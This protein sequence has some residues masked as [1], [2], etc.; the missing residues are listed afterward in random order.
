[1]VFSGLSRARGRWIPASRASPSSPQRNSPPERVT[2]AAPASGPAASP[3]P[4]SAASFPAPFAA[5]TKWAGIQSHVTTLPTPPPPLGTPLRLVGG[6]FPLFR[7][8][9]TTWALQPLA[10]PPW[11]PEGPPG[12][13]QTGTGGE[14]VGS[15]TLALE[16]DLKTQTGGICPI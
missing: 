2:S 1:M 8:A 3:P 7:A 9:L 10:V 16:L 14:S 12:T 4:A 13:A 15:N 5:E 6:C 11:D